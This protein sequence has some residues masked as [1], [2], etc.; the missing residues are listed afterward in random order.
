MQPKQANTFPKKPT[1]TPIPSTSFDKLHLFG[2]VNE[3]ILS[4]KTLLRNLHFK[5]NDWVLYEMNY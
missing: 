5:S 2:T 1:T 3:P 4:T